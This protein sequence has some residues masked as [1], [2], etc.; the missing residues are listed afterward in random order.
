MTETS[1]SEL[2]GRYARGDAD[3]FDQLF[4]R[5][6]RPIFAFF[7]G[8]ARCPDRAADLH[9]ELFLRLHRFRDHFDSARPFTPWVFALAR[10]VW[11]DDLRRRHGVVEREDGI[12]VE[13]VDEDFESRLLSGDQARRLLEVL[14]PRERALVL[15]TAVV[16]YSYAELAPR[17]RRSVDSL[18]QAGSR[19]LR[20]LRRRSAD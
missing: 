10:N 3:A 19:A 14:A 17:T 4:G 16:G 5:Y 20:K 11:H 18:K 13:A 15:E 1:D 12:E 6:D 8:R 2:M 9:Q 7:L